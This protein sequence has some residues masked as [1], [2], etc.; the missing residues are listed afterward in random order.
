[1]FICNVCNRQTEPGEQQT[2]IVVETR[3]KEYINEVEK[4]GKKYTVRSKGQEIVKEHK[5]CPTCKPSVGILQNST[6]R[7]EFLDQTTSFQ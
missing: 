5:V 4:E 7:Q 3:E 6:P 2:R 1:M